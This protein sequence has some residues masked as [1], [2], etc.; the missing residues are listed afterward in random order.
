MQEY[1]KNSQCAVRWSPLDISANSGPIELHQPQMTCMGQSVEWKLAGETE[2]LSA[3]FP[4]A[5]LS[6]T[7]PIWSNLGMNPGSHSWKPETNNLSYEMANMIT[8]VIWPQETY[9]LSLCSCLE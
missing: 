3:I 9:L 7:N 5:I 4:S 1:E 6:T 8:K 2:M